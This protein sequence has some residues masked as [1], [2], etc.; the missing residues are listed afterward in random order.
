MTPTPVGSPSAKIGQLVQHDVR[1]EVTN[2]LDECLPVEDITK[3][4]FGTEAAQ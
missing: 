4:R 2:S 3:D 1:F